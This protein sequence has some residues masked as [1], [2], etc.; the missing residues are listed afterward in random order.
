MRSMDPRPSSDVAFTPSVKAI[1]ACKGSRRAYA[2]MEEAGGWETKITPALAEFIGRQTSV[3]FATA[4]ADGQPYVQHRGGPAGFLR[5]LDERTLA[6]ADFRGNRQ[7][8]SAGNLAEN[9]KA[10]LFLL[11]Y[12]TRERIKIWG[13]ARVVEDD[14]ALLAR[15]MPPGY[16]AKGE[17]V[18]LF[19]VVA[20]DANCPQ[21]IPQRVETQSPGHSSNP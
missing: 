1:Q 10:Q 17:H 18:I 14:P 4:S 16:K 7:Y 5:V 2:H 21:H 9:P 11:D 19:S 12:S 8:I 20:W 3:F 13:T 6:F 15:L